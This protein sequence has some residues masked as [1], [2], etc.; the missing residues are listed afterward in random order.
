MLQHLEPLVPADDH[1]SSLVPD[2][3]LDVTEF[4]YAALQLLELRV[5][6]LQVF[7]GIVLRGEQFLHA[8]L[9]NVHTKPH[10]ANFSNPPILR[11]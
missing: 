10:S 5:T 2:D 9:F 7:S 6:G 1:T 4:G 8:D 11:M 3:R